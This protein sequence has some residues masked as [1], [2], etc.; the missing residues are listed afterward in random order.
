METILTTLLK[1][2]S[3]LPEH[4]L[5][6]IDDFYM[7]DSQPVDQSLAFLIYCSKEGHRG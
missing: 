4:F 5:F 7:N 1:E 2:I 3:V 6:I